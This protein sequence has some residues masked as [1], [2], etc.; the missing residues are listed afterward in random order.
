MPKPSHRETILTEGL[1]VVHARGFAGASVRNIIQAAGVP[2]GSFTNHFAS[3]EAFC[4]EVLDRYFDDTRALINR[5]LRNDS[6][7][8]LQRLRAFL[9]ATF[10]FLDRNGLENGCLIGNFSVEASDHSEIIRQ[11]I[12]EIFEELQQSVAYCLRAAVKVGELSPA[13]ECDDIAGFVVTSH[14]GAVLRSKAERSSVAI[15]RFKRIVF[16][17]ILRDPAVFTPKRA[18]R[19]QR[20][21]KANQ[22]S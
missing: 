7:P 4:L 16:S 9:D 8:P 20:S 2:Q 10:K 18:A 17:T 15:E 21:V 14:Q 13:T 19:N 5:T 11:R 12:V 22:S 3:K 1:R 6:L